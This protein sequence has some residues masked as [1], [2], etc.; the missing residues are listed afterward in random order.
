MSHNLRLGIIPAYLMLCL[1][2]GGASAAG[3]WANMLLQLLAIPIIFWSLIVERQTAMSASGRQL[4]GLLALVLIA[5]LIQLIP[6]PP[7]VWSA[8]PGRDQVAA[9]FE[10]LGQPLPWLS[11][12][13]APYSTLASALWLLPAIATLLGIVRLGAFRPNWIAVVIAVATTAGVMIGALQ[14]TSG[15]PQASIWYLY[16]ITNYG[17]AVGFFSN[18]NH[19]ATLLIVTIPFLAA[20]FFVARTKA[21][22]AQQ[23]S[24]MFVILCGALAVIAVGLVINSSLAGLGLVVPVVA[25][26]ALIK[27]SKSRL[28]DRI[29]PA[30]IAVLAMASI[31]AIFS[32]PFG[33][34][35]TGQ[36]AKDSQYSR[37]ASFSNSLK[38]AGDYAPIGS[39]TGTFTEVYPKYEEANAVTLTYINHVHSDYIEILLE[40]G[41]AGLALVLCFVA[42]WVRRVI[43]IW[44]HD[45]ADYFARAATIA[46]AAIL[47]HS[48]VDYPLRTAAIS[49]IFA[50]CC[51][52]MTLPRPFGTRK[53]GR[54][55]R[56]GKHLTAD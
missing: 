10:M 19:M 52:L 40:T 48:A 18:A 55:T 14:I 28:I 51:A 5:T 23:A 7:A 53:K 29:A 46:S 4:L 41:L 50:A 2:L 25:A 11:L 31:V 24:G 27:R 45:D 32:A 15:N 54:G 49:A 36:G 13:L 43:A 38:A 47:A 9:G 20:V 3:I 44:S 26:S 37:Y 21:R 16:D 39:G 30:L 35:L 56:Q 22:S 42:W 33:N 8:L 1:L 6:L 17:V 12:S 34:N